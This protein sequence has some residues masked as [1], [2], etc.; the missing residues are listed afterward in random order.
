MGRYGWRDDSG[1]TVSGA[2]AKLRHGLGG[3]ADP[4]LGPALNPERASA[5]YLLWVGGQAR[6][7]VDM[8]GGVYLR[9]GI[10]HA[11]MPTLAYRVETP[12][13]SVVFSSDQNGTDPKFVDFSRDAD[14]LINGQMTWDG[15]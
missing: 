13:G 12:D 1:H 2:C 6:M 3:G 14:T 8:G 7:L 4:R 15:P 11:N 5:S 10:P 9:F